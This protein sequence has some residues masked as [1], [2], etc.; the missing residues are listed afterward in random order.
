MPEG[1]GQ[2][3]VSGVRLRMMKGDADGMTKDEDVL[4]TSLNLNTSWISETHKH[5]YVLTR[6]ATRTCMANEQDATPYH[7][8]GGTRPSRRHYRG[9]AARKQEVEL[10][11]GRYTSCH[12]KRARQPPS[13]KTQLHTRP[14]YNMLQAILRLALHWTS[15]P[16]WTNITLC[17]RSTF[18][19]PVAHRSEWIHANTNFIVTRFSKPR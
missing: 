10:H 11:P 3:D 8:Y 19:P 2:Y 18:E 7:G 6:I 5:C 12:C 1:M 9:Y 4:K 15:A 14:N 13:S 17:L 16:A